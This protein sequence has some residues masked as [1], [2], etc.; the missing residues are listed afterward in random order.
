LAIGVAALVTALALI[1]A[2]VLRSTAQ[3]VQELEVPRT[4]GMT[5]GEV[6]RAAAAGPVIA[7]VVGSCAATG[8]AVLASR[9]F[10][11]GSAAISEPTPGIAVDGAVLGPAAAAG[12]L[13]VGALSIGYAVLRYGLAGRMDTGHRSVVAAATARA[14]LPVPVV[15]GARFALEAG[16]G[17]GRGPAP[18]RPALVAAVAGVA[19]ILAALTF[20]GGVADAADN[21]ARFGQTAQFLEW[22]R[23]DPVGKE[24]VSA[25][26]L[27]TSAAEDRDVV[28]VNDTRVSVAEADDHSTSISMYSFAPVGHPMDV[29]LVGGRMPSSGSEAVLAPE[30]AS[31]LGARIGRTVTLVGDRGPLTL[32][33]S[34]IGFVPDGVDNQYSNGGWVTREGFDALFRRYA[35]HVGRITVREGVE[36]ETVRAR[37]AGAAIPATGEG[38]RIERL[39]AVEMMK[40]VARVRFLPIALGGFLVLLAVGTVGHGLASVAVR[41]QHELAVLRA[42]GMT[43]RQCRA[44]VT[45][46][47]ATLATVGLVVGLPLGVAA[48]RAMWRVVADFAP[49]HYVPPRAIGV[50]LLAIPLTLLIAG[51]LA[52]WPGRRAARLRIGQVLRA[53]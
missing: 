16:R 6:L 5:P 28:A 46:H 53:E 2:A 24:D 49:A 51:L 8:L 12:P 29:V 26:R 33:M 41:R 20:S 27:L 19:G 25:E 4:L 17:R 22:Y 48:G 11:L 40:E 36:V 32:T 31:A 50:V 7:A 9:W 30:S 42:L 18:A 14:G 10:P 21:P 52:A 39:D 23:P 35:Y 45:I 44:V 47:A 34:G 38:V 1:G 13:L 3:A 43:R 37:L 15:V